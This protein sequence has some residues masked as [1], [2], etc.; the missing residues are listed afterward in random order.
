MVSTRFADNFEAETITVRTDFAGFSVK[1]FG[2]SLMIIDEVSKKEHIVA[3]FSA[4]GDLPTLAELK[5]FVTEK[6]KN[7]KTKKIRVYSF[8]QG[9]SVEKIAD[10]IL[11]NGS[12]Y[13]KDGNYIRK[14]L[15]ASL[16]TGAHK[17]AFKLTRTGTIRVHIRVGE[18]GSIRT[19]I[20]IHT[21]LGLST[22]WV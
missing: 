12:D 20:H 3:P 11:E 2:P 7:K 10:L 6:A 18:H 8:D 19:H 21:L 15:I 9:I 13:D 1:R 5:K 14:R 16:V 4:D 22:L 17:V